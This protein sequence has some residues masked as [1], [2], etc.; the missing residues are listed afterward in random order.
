MTKL[1]FLP[2]DIFPGGQ[3]ENDY[4][5]IE[6]K[7]DFSGRPIERKIIN[8]YFVV[9]VDKELLP[10]YNWMVNN[11]ANIKWEKLPFYIIAPASM[12]DSVIPGWHPKSGTH[13]DEN[14]VEQPNTFESEGLVS[15][16]SIDQSEI[17][18]MLGDLDKDQLLSMYTMVN[19]DVNITGAT[20]KD[21]DGLIK[22]NPSW[23]TP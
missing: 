16:Y 11:R 17:I 8:G 12:A 22:G 20:N 19:N 10:G 13:L 9:S 7:E 23:E 5:K 14:E 18:I 15:R 1:G 4:R 3:Y 6:I 2:S 21:L